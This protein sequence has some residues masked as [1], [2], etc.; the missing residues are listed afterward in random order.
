ME[1]NNLFTFGVSKTYSKVRLSTP[2]I[3]ISTGSTHHLHFPLLQTQTQNQPMNSM[4]TLTVATLAAVVAIIFSLQTPLLKLNQA[5]AP[6]Q[7]PGTHD[8]LHSATVIPVPGAIGPESLI[9]DP[10]GE[11]PYTGVADGRILKWQG[12]GRGWTDFAVTSSQRYNLIFILLCWFCFW[13]MFQ[14]IVYWLIRGFWTFTKIVLGEGFLA[15]YSVVWLWNGVA[16]LQLDI[17]I[18]FNK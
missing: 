2:P 4:L 18:F 16:W 9:F 1:K 11:G 15:K 12:D 5:F 8:Y 10:N 13:E 3:P 14:R 6:P 7:I 17:Y